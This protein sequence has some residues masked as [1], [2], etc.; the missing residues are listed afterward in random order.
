MRKALLFIAA[1]LILVSGPAFA[2]GLSGE[3][4]VGTDGK[5]EG[6]FSQYLFYD[7]DHISVL[8]R[9]FWVNGVLRRGEIALGSTVKLGKSTVL[10]LQFGGTTDREVMLA[11]LI[12]AKAKGHEILYIAD[13]KLATQTGPDTLYQKIFVAMTKGGALQ[14][15]AEDLL[16]GN[17]HSFLRIGFEYRQALPHRT[18]LFVA[19]DYDPIRKAFGGQFGLRFF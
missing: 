11:G 3:T 6:F 17:D 15:R 19:P 2:Q 7:V 5:G 13:E 16:V 18:H 12:V 1:S 14:F 9:Y 10:K 8:T 4:E